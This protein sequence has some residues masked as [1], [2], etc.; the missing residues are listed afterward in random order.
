MFELVAE[1]GACL[2]SEGE[3][4]GPEFRI[5]FE[6]VLHL[7]DGSREH[8]RLSSNCTD[9]AEKRKFAEESID[10]FRL[11]GLEPFAEIEPGTAV[12]ELVPFD[13]VELGNVAGSILM[14]L[15]SPY[16]GDFVELVGGIHLRGEIRSSL[17]ASDV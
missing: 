3:H 14:S 9:L 8:L 10:D 17:V 15:T 13:L 12:F 11:A 6:K 7:R 1:I 16:F 5:A 2:D 4:E